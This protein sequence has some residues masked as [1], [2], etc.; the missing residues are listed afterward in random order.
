MVGSLVSHFVLKNLLNVPLI[1]LLA[2]V[3]NSLLVVGWL[4][5]CLLS[6]WLVV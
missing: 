4:V 3:D 1:T 2:L 6:G 5:I